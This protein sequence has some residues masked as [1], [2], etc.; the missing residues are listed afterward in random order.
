MKT[1]RYYAGGAWHEPASGRWIESENPALGEAWA[2]LPDCGAEDVD[3]AVRAAHGC[4]HNGPWPR[5]SLRDRARLVRR[6]GDVIAANAER[7]GA[8]ETR[9]NGKLPAHITP[10]LTTWLYE[11]FPYYAGMIDKFEGALIPADAPDM[12][13]YL[14]WEPFGVAAL[15]TA[16]NSPLGVLIW[17]LAPALAAGNTVVIKPSEHASASTLELMAVLEEADLPPGLVNVVTGYGPTTGEPLVDHA[18]VRMVSFTGGVPGG[19]AVAAAAARQVKPVVMELGGKSPQIVLEDADLELAVNG[20]AG[21]I[22]PVS[23]QSCVAGSRALVHR[24][25]VEAFSERLVAAVEK[26]RIGD[27]GDPA[28]QIGPLANQP[29]YEGVLEEIAKAEQTGARLLLD[30]RGKGPDKGYYLGPTIFA[31]VTNDMRLAQHEIFGPVVAV[32]PFDD[33]AEAVAMANDSIFGLAAG[34]WTRD[35]ARAIRLADRIEAGTVYINNYF[36]AAT[37]S[38]VG[39]FKQSG[40]GRENG[41]EGLRCFMQ[42]KSVWLATNPNEPAPFGG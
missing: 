21:G 3:R 22:F 14:R 39:G 25:L 26:A 4:F 12:L 31:E 9:D 6:I 32:I 33:E 34:I 7:L 15:I 11:S 30:G 20:V 13:N 8:V 27:P 23:G 16:W 24:N 18:K 17:K 37:Q 10:A 19:R 1:Y 36:N 41:F 5:M 29:H 40:Y 35:T 38:P 28:T 42:T 2:R